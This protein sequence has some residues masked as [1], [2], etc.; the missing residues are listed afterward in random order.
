MADIYATDNMVE[1]EEPQKIPV[2]ISSCLL[3]ER[4]RYDGGHKYNA[5]IVNKLNEYFEFLPFCPEMD[6][7]LGSPREPVKLI[8]DN[9]KIRCVGTLTP[10][11]DITDQLADCANQQR[12]WHNDICGYI[13]KK[14]SPSCGPDGVNLLDGND[15]AKNGIGIYAK[16]IVRNFPNLPV[17]DENQFRNLAFQEAFIQ[18]VI[19]YQRW[20]SLLSSKLN[21]ETLTNFHG[22]HKSIL[23]RRDRPLT[24]ALTL[25]LDQSRK[26]DVELFQ[27][28]YIDKLSA[29]LKSVPT[30]QNNVNTEPS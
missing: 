29:I 30:E 21:R 8:L 14:N 23:I 28:I 1:P 11:L 4:V 26:N 24:N 6:I 9:D 20:K 16:Q 10:S 17:A 22:F 5:H 27:Q 12:S 7:G 2:G 18:R 15:L 13:F 25:L 19:I 3:G